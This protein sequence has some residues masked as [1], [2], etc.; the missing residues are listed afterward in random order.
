MSAH[1]PCRN[2]RAPCVGKRTLG[3]PKR[4]AAVSVPLDSHTTVQLHSLPACR[5]SWRTQ[6]AG[7][8]EQFL[9]ENFQTDAGLVET[10]DADDDEVRAPTNVFLTE[11]RR[12]ASAY[13]Q[14]CKNGAVNLGSC[15]AA[16]A[17]LRL[18]MR[19]ITWRIPA[20]L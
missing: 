1:L 2:S 14:R 5:R 13:Q 10:V 16:Q 18:V 12:A 7:V 15:E 20:G 4:P 8:E 19:P 3:L 17:E 9:M 6:A 11:E